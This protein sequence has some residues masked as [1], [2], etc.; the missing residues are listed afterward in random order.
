ME[1]VINYLIYAVAIVGVGVPVFGLG[2][3]P[4]LVV[5]LLLSGFGGNIVEQLER[6]G[7]IKITKE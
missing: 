3:A 7:I 4:G 5:N 2:L 6:E 1:L